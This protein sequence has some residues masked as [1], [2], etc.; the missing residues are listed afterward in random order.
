[1]GVSSAVVLKEWYLDQQQQWHLGICLKCTFSG[2]SPDPRSL[3][4]Q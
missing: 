1:M 3:A 4:L 2:S